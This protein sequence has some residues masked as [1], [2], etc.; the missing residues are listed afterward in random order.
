MRYPIVTMLLFRQ[1]LTDFHN[2]FI[3]GKYVKFAT[4][5]YI[6]LPTT[7]KMCCCTTS[8]NVN[9]QICC[10]FCILYCV[11]IKSNYQTHGG[12]LITS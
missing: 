4:K 10:I 7:H 5:Q 9:V 2:S 6:T 8:T 1:I 3:A 11:P 12:N